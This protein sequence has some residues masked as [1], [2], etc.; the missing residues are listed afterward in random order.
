MAIKK[1]PICGKE[2]ETNNPKRALCSPECKEANKKAYLQR[3]RQENKD[4]VKEQ[5]QNYKGTKDDEGIDY[6]YKYQNPLSQVAE[7]KPK[8]KNT[9]AELVAADK[10]A[11]EKGM[12][13][14]QYKAQCY[15][16]QMRAEQEAALK[17]AKEVL[18]E[19]EKEGEAWK[20]KN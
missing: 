11:K 4:R 13:Y 18:G 16:A 20:R 19:G 12:T 8:H 5:Y 6:R 1:C 3:W 17:K 2:F 7:K 10:A 9:E 14:G 15:I